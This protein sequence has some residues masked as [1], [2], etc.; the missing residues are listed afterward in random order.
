MIPSWMRRRDYAWLIRDH[1]WEASLVERIQR[2]GEGPHVLS[3]DDLCPSASYETVDPQGGWEA[4]E[5][6]SQN[7]V[8]ANSAWLTDVAIAR[9]KELREAYKEDL[10]RQREAAAK[11]REE[12]E[13]Q[14]AAER[15]VWQTRREERRKEQ[16]AYTAARDAELKHDGE[17][18][19]IL[20]GKWSCTV[21]NGV[22]MVEKSDDGYLLTCLSCRK[23]A[24]GSHEALAKVLAR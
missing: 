9:R 4:A 17:V 20:Y 7:A 11:E 12:R 16:E 8:R 24:W 6:R 13:K 18:R 23:T 10:A 3:I 21:C 15:L 2:R 19:N 5:R 14:E 22:A 1:E